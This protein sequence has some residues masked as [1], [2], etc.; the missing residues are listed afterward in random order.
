M[1]TINW[2]IIKSKDRGIDYG[3]GT[4]IR[5][6]T[7]GLSKQ[8]GIEVFV[9]EIDLLT[10]FNIE[11]KDGISYFRF[12]KSKNLKDLDTIVN[13]T[14]LAKGIVRLVLP[15]LPKDRK[16]VVHMNFAFQ[17][18]IGS[19]FKK[20]LDCALIFT[21][22]LFIH[23]L[24]TTDNTFDIERQTYAMVDRIITV[25]NHG[26]EH[27]INKLVD[28]LKITTIYNG[29][30]PKLFVKNGSDTN[31]RRKYGISENEKIVLYSGRIDPIKGLK[32]LS[33]AFSILL[34]KFPD[35]RLVIAGNGDYEELIRCSK[36]FS[37]TI[38]Y[39]GFIPFEDLVA[40]YH[41]A[42][43]GVIPSLEEHCSY[44]A[45]EMLY[46]GLPVVA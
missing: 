1:K 15:L 25:T 12:P 21:Q 38:N 29:I 26:K 18:F 34:K 42:T 28:K 13:H 46:C 45:L 17:Y 3:V 40:L 44:V 10:E 23:K 32:Y 14:K 5:Q 7:E 9:I 39:L 11:I 4:F 22:H 30:D 24:V 41:E 36:S 33:I 35:C 20:V 43:I 31:I 2:I 37:S 19:E 6:I 27:L 16:T 8:N